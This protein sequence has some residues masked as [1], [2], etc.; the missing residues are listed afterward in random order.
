MNST[1][2]IH[3]N[4]MHHQP[5]IL[6]VDDNEVN[7]SF[8]EKLLQ[9]VPANL[10]MALSGAEAL[11]KT[12]GIHPALAI[13]DVRM[14]GMDG[15][16]LAVRLNVDR[17][18]EKVP[19]IF[20]T[21]NYPKSTEVIKG[22]ECGAV[23]YIVKPVDNRILLSKIRVFIDLFNQ[24]R[25][26]TRA[27]GDIHQLVELADK[28]A[29]TVS[30]LKKS[31]ENYRLL[32]ENSHDII[33]SINQAG[34]FTY[35]SPMW[36][37]LLGHPLSQV[38]GKPFRLFVHPDDV[39]ACFDW[40]QLVIDTG[41]R[42][43][44][45]EYRVQHLNGTWY[46]YTTNAVPVYDESGAPTRFL[47]IARDITERRQT[48]ERLDQ[49]R[50]NYETFFNAI[51]QFLI[52]LDEDG[53]IVYTNPTVIDRLGFT[54]DELYGKS[55]LLLHPV[56]RRDEAGRIVN[57]M[58]NGAKT[59]CPVPLITK[60]GTQIPVETRVFHGFWDGKPA[61]FGVTED[62]SKVR[63]SEE[64]FSKVFYLN[65]SACGLSDLVSGKYVELNHAFYTLLGFHKEEVIGKTVAD[66]GIIGEEEA[67]AI[68]RNTDQ[69]GKVTNAEAS[70]KTKNGDIK[71]VLLSAETI[72]VQDRTY[73]FTV[74]HDITD[75]KLVEKG[76][77]ALDQIRQLGQYTEKARE[78]ERKS[79]ARELHDDLGQL[80]TAAKI[81]L[82]MIRKEVPN[83]KLAVKISKTM[84]LVTDTIKTVQ[85]ITSNLRPEIIKD[86]GLEA[87]I[88]WYTGEFSKRTGIEIFLEIDSEIVISPD[89]SL[90]IYRIM[91]EAMT[92]I[93]RHSGAT[94][95]NLTLNLAG[96]DLCLVISDNGTGITE[97]QIQASN[98]FGIMGMAERV[99][100]LGGT[101]NICRGHEQG[102][103]IKIIFPADI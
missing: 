35:V 59:F 19:I 30:A 100:S 58:L 79:I 97:T 92:N 78:N 99:A 34:V 3:K 101:F 95:V 37:A 87:A 39:A 48:R 81:D 57:E 9:N 60:A 44:G 96:N 90:T 28:L 46:W 72:V 7:L 82:G 20:L 40:I 18:S 31:E 68:I 13:V 22:Y 63:L 80:L 43:E 53:N 25:T 94:R 15:Y 26:I 75:R 93:A 89:H 74:F 17:Q 73:L 66:L 86:L 91:Q 47:G 5:D 24:K 23:D 11:E 45:L 29:V 71:Q 6:I 33:F 4:P 56:E 51:D 88:E 64:K 12:H 62:I 54:K 32:V 27:A 84:D 16:E 14:P 85:R 52:V 10:I 55:I 21:A 2:N 8:L 1:E 50:Q 77:S 103:I 65:P 69:N 83:D 42:Q 38:V 49:I 102:T 61:I 70:L 36:T 67:D 41:Q 76:K 98:S